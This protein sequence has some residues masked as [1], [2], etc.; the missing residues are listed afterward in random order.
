MSAFQI[1]CFNCTSKEKYVFQLEK[2]TFYYKKLKKRLEAGRKLFVT[3][4]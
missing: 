4:V 1:T 3:D 2:E